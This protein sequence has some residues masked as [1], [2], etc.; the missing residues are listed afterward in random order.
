M[1]ATGGAPERATRIRGTEPMLDI[2]ALIYE[3]HDWFRRHFFY[4]DHAS[5]TEDLTAIW[6][7]LGTRLDVHAEAEEV[8]FY[9]ALLA[10]GSADD[11]KDETLDAIKDH[12]KIRDAVAEANRHPVGSEEW[13]KAV[14]VARK[15]NGEHLDEEEREGLPDFIR[16]ASAQQRHDLALAWLRFYHA[17]PPANSPGEADLKVSDKDPDGYVEAMS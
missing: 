8:V 6:Q 3:D 7:P 10:A 15:E 9:P 13:R 17:H 11:P 12:N 2:I 5:T 14:S 1:V 16:N 4:L